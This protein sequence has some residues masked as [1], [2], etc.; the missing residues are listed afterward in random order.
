MVPERLV[1]RFA[2]SGAFDAARRELVGLRTGSGEIGES[3]LYFL[4]R[5]WLG[6]PDAVSND[7]GM[8]PIW[9][10]PQVPFAF[11]YGA[12]QVLSALPSAAVYALIAAAY[13]LVY[14]L[15]GRVMLG[16]GEV[17]AL[18]SIAAVVSVATSLTLD[19]V[20]PV[21]AIAIAMLVAVL[22]VRAAW[23]C[24]RAHAAA[25]VAAWQR[26]AGAHSHGRPVAGAIGISA[27]GTR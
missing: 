19:P 10:A 11:A 14:G 21:T 15:I 2:A 12:Q 6:T 18:G 1:C 20:T 16:F 4:K 24:G 26:P 7:P 13:A 8:P 3:R 27:T 23:L 9:R 25:A 17:A 22:V 5:F